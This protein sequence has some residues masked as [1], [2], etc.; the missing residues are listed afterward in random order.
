[1]IALFPVPKTLTC[2]GKITVLVAQNYSS[3]LFWEGFA[4]VDKATEV[5]S[6]KQGE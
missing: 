5:K 3:R 1:V 2:T 6:T 4:G